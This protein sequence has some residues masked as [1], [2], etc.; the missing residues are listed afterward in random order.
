MSEPEFQN[1]VDGAARLLAAARSPVIAGLGTDIAGVIAAFK[2]AETIGAA[3]DHDC[4]GSLLRDLAVLRETG[5]LLVTPSEARA[6]ADT[7][8]LVGDRPMAA[9]PELADY[10]FDD[11]VTQ[12]R[13]LLSIAARESKLGTA[14]GKVALLETS[15]HDIPQ[16]L[17]ALRARVN[18][19]PI[20]DVTRLGELDRFAEALREATYGVAI[21]SPEELDALSIEMLAGLVSDLNE[22]TRWSSFSVPQS[23]SAAGATLAAA[24]MTGFPLRTA[25]VNGR[26]EHD[27]WRFDARRLLASGEADAA[28]YICSYQDPPPDWLSDIPAVLLVNAA[29]LPERRNALRITVG[30]P[31][32]D[33][34]SVLYDR[35]TATLT[36]W[37]ASDPSEIPSVAHVLNSIAARLRSR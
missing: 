30:Q 36:H 15:S 18:G 37:P 20:G 26:W 9:W 32:R 13:R 27:P 2:L 16:R 35:R 19:R 1:V 6:R 29:T 33:H 17:G 8:L 24:W 28:I 21:W 23:G 10:L 12:E 31:A 25:F 11:A 7:L 4:A 5:M 22:G 34:D 14:A 3:V